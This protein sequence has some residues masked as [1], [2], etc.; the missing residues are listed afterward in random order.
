MMDDTISPL[1]KN[2][3][4]FNISMICAAMDSNELWSPNH[5]PMFES[6]TLDQTMLAGAGAGATLTAIMNGV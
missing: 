5:S 3:A 4:M 2:I 1:V 6:D